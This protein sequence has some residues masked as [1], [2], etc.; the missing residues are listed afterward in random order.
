MAFSAVTPRGS[1]TEKTSDTSISLS[2][3]A[4]L[5]VGQLVVVHCATDNDAVAVADGA[6]TRHSLADSKGN[7][8]VKDA[9]YT[10]SDGAAADGVTSSV[11]HSV[12][13]TAILTSDTITLTTS[14]A[15]TNKIISCLEATMQAGST[16][17]V[18]TVGVGQ[19]AIAATATGLLPAE[20]LFVGAGASEGNDNTKTADADYAEQFDLRTG[21][22]T[23]ATEICTHVVTRIAID[24]DDTCTST[25][26]TNTNPIFLLVPYYEIAGTLHSTIKENFDDN[27]IDG[28]LWDAY[29]DGVASTVAEANKRAELAPGPST[30]FSYASFDG[31]LAHNL[32]ADAIFI[33][34]PQV[35]DNS[36]TLFVLWLDDLNQVRLQTD[37]G[38]FL[39]SKIAVGAETEIASMAYDPAVHRYWRIRESGGSLYFEYSADG[40]RNWTEIGGSSHTTLPFRVTSSKVRL[41]VY[42]DNVASP[43][44]AYFDNY[45]I[46]PAKQLAALGVG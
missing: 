40:W 43:G 27:S 45:N 6:T 13:T 22:G 35:T 11:W 16:V 5:A 44:A 19:S 28:A 31:V 46:L 30:P 29:N 23:A 4:N 26:W 17:G 39:C 1:N 33:C 41:N 37:T 42:A 20:Y 18:A 2:P 10:D 38:N 32:T 34:A 36:E 15:V 24:D 21:S 25:G 14:S 7:T 12:L 8:W 3:S 9:E